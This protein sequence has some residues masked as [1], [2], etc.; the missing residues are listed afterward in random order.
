VREG[1]LLTGKAAG[2]VAVLASGGTAAI[3]NVG[4]RVMSPRTVAQWSGPLSYTIVEGQF[5]GSREEAQKKKVLKQD[6]TALLNYE[7]SLANRVSTP[8]FFRGN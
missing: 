2:P 3:R 6:T 5:I 4:Y 7:V 1:Q 8:S